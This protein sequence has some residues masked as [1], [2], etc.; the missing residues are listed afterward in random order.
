MDSVKIVQHE[1]FERLGLL[2][3]KE[4]LERDVATLLA[5]R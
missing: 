3:L 2:A 4:I 5:E 1:K